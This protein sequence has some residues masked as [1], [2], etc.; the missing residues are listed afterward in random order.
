MPKQMVSTVD[1]QTRKASTGQ[2]YSRKDLHIRWDRRGSL[3][4]GKER[5][6][7]TSWKVKLFQVKEALEVEVQRQ[8]S[9]P[10]CVEA[11]GR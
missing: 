11:E 9:T 7:I 4:G 6:E 8:Q 1:S 10:Y 5:K 2:V 3:N